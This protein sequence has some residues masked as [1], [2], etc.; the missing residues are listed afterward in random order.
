MRASGRRPGGG[1]GAAAV[2]LLALLAACGPASGGR[3]L[4]DER[5][6]RAIR[7]HYDAQ[8]REAEGCG[9]PFITRIRSARIAT[10]AVFSGPSSIL[11]DHE[12]EA[13]ALAPG[14]PPCTG[15]GRRTFR[16]LRGIDGPVVTG[17]SGAVR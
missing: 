11:V 13:P 10:D 17:M 12:W 5:V 16:V 2:A 4:A 1:R 3:L 14:A 7:A 6:L 15:Q 8:A 9:E